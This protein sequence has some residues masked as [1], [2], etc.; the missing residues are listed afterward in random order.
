MCGARL[1]EEMTA[2]LEQ[3][4]NDPAAVQAYGVEYAVRQ[5]QD[6]LDRGAP[7]IHFYTL[8]KSP[9]TRAIY[10]RLLG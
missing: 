3:I 5:C 6:L 8:N 9:S 2:D 1:P 10:S 7:G 4:Q